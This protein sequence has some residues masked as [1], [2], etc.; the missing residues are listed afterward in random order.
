MTSGHATHRDLA[1]PL[2][3]GGVGILAAGQLREDPESR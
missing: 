3:L 1:A 2:F